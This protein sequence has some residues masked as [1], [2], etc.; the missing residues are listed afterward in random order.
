MPTEISRTTHHIDARTTTLGRIATQ[1]AN[2]LRGKNKIQFAP[3]LDIG[4][5]VIITNARDLRITGR[6]LTQ[7]VYT[8]HTS[9]PGGFRQ[10]TLQEQLSMDPTQVVRRAIYGMLPKNRLR[11]L[12]INRLK[13]Y[14]DEA[15]EQIIKQTKE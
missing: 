6:K 15:P 3:H 4:D 14:L 1:T 11:K 5:Y 12:W 13:I 10:K 2:L 8:H 9:Y 7:K